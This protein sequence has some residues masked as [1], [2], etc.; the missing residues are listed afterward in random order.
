MLI[1]SRHIYIWLIYL[2]VDQSC[3]SWDRFLAGFATRTERRIELKSACSYFHRFVLLKRP[4]YFQFDE[5]L[6]QTVKP[7][8]CP[9]LALVIVVIAACLAI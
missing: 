3:S 2:Q 1:S 5:Y 9:T 8:P 4:V 6:F 7:N